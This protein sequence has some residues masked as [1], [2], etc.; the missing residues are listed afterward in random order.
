MRKS[1]LRSRER[2][3]KKRPRYDEGPKSRE[4]NHTRSKT[5]LPQTALL[6]VA[7]IPH[8]TKILIRKQRN[9]I[10]I[11]NIKVRIPRFSD[12]SSPPA[13]IERIQPRIVERHPL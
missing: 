11:C 5:Y 2:P 6:M 8:P 1:R 13:R 7:N 3:N 12:L 4:E 9:R 10:I